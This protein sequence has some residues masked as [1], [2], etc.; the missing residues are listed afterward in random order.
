ME[1]FKQVKIQTPK[2]E[3]TLEFQKVEVPEE[4]HVC[5]VCCSYGRACLNLRDPRDPSNPEKLFQ[6]FCT[7][8]GKEGSESED[9]DLQSMVPVPGTIEKNLG[10]FEDIYQ[11]IIKS[12]P[13]VK[14]SQVIEKVCSGWCD[15]YNPE[16]SNC[17]S[18]NSLCM[19]KDLFIGPADKVEVEPYD[20][21][22]EMLEEL[23]RKRAEE[24][25]KNKKAE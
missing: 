10:D 14:L 4:T 6:H 22:I 8:L 11:Q 2:G 13:Q 12:D 7:N 23:D 3:R 16:K 17:N 5:N 1:K 18:N 25:A 15:M 9:S 20:P 21:D 24:E 19:L